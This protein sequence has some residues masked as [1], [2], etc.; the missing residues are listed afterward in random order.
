M[1][2]DW[3]G[4]FANLAV[5][6]PYVRTVRWTHFSDAEPHAYP[7]CG[8]IDAAGQPKP[9]LATLQRLRAEHLK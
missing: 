5:C 1:Q 4:A 6:K 2:A 3:I 9:G 7:H 8:L